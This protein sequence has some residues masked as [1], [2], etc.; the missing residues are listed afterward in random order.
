[1]DGARIR[2][3]KVLTTPHDVSECFMSCVRA[4]SEA[5]DLELEDFLLRTEV[6]RVSTTIGTN[7][8]VQRAGPRI[9]LI[10]T[11]GAERDLYG[12]GD[13]IVLERYIA[14]NMVLG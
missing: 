13:A 7:L 3:R 10:V 4:G 1:S 6:A 9:G 12:R 5:F 11:E 8:L 14:A 2:T